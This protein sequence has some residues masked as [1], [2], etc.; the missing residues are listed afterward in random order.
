VTPFRSLLG[1]TLVGLF[2]VPAASAQVAVTDPSTTLRNAVTAVL[3]N[4]ILDTTTEQH[5]RLRRMARRLSMHTDLRKYAVPDPPRWRTHGSDLFLYTA[6]MNDA[7]IF[8]DPQGAAYVSVSRPIGP[9]VTPPASLTPAARR[10]LA[11]QLATIELTD[12]TAIAGIHQTGQLRFNGRK[13]EL[14]AIAALEAQVV[15]PS[16]E[17]SA[18]AVLDKIAGA[19]LIGARQRQARIQL[20]AAT[21]E[22]LLVDNKRTRDAEAASMTMQLAKLDVQARTDD[23]QLL[24]GAGEQ[25][26]AWR[27]P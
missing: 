16:Q 9:R 14:P 10:L 17:Q 23:A 8:G 24:S 19:T 21:L 3:K 2:L 6:A 4:R 1:A 7:L 20:L 12:A 15:D 5:R 22:Q 13:F 11:S 26:R 27:Q 18:A 25:L